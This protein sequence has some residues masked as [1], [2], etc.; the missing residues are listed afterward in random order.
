METIYK[1]LAPYRVLVVDDD[2][3][4]RKWLV[5]VLAIYLKEAVYAE[6]ALEALDLFKEKPFDI[7]IADIQMPDIDGLTFLQ[8]IQT[9][10]PSTYRVIMTAFNNTLYLNRAVGCNVPLYLKKPI[11]IDELL[12]SL[13]SHM[14][15]TSNSLV[16]L[17][18]DFTYELEKKMVYKNNKV[19]KLTKKEL[20]LLELLLK[21]KQGYLTFEVIESNIWQEST[22]TD[23][24]RMVIVGLRKKLYSQLIENM[25]GL[26]YRLNL[27]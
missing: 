12:V 4:T 9:L 25:K 21:N 26:G 23:A 17:G 15:D 19:V 8:K 24:I 11:D 18:E 27:S 2:E 7:V 1:R 20:L 6:N 14:P 5:R 10:S 16:N 22:T 13:S 3:S